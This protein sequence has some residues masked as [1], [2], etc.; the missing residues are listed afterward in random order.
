MNKKY[1]RDIAE[2]R[3]TVDKLA[4][5]IP[6]EEPEVEAANT[7]LSSKSSKGQGRSQKAQ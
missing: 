1:V 2:L 5:M 7:E 6:S 4:A 3:D